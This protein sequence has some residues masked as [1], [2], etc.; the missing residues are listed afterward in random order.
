M[1]FLLAAL[2]LTSFEEY[3]HI[4]KGFVDEIL[5]IEDI[6]NFKATCLQLWIS[7]LQQS[8]A[9]FFDKEK[10]AT[11]KLYAVYRKA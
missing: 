8:E 7:Y 1:Q 2:R 9:A 6:P 4:L 3:N 10:M 5:T 11:P